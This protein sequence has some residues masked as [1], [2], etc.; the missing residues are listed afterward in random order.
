MI[1]KNNQVAISQMISYDKAVDQQA[2]S[3]I[4]SLLTEPILK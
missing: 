3:D 4:A 1:K 2:S